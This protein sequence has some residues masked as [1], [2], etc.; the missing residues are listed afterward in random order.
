VSQKYT[1]HPLEVMA[2]PVGVAQ[3][4]RWRIAALLLMG[5]CDSLQGE[6]WGREEMGQVNTVCML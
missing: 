3:L 1:K 5:K 2:G 6:E 4:L